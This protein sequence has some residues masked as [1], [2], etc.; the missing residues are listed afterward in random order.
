MSNVQFARQLSVYEHEENVVS[1]NIQMII[2]VH[3][4]VSCLSYKDMTSWQIYKIL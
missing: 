4:L 2:K 3:I 1:F